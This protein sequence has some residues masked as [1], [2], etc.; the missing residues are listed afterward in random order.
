MTFPLKLAWLL[1]VAALTF[2]SLRV[3]AQDVYISEV[4]SSNDESLNDEDG[5]SPDWIELFNSSGSAV[6]LTGW[7][8]TDDSEDLTK[9]TFPATTIPAKGFLIVFASDKDRAVANQELHTNFKLS[10]SGEYIALVQADGTTIEN[11]HTLGAQV[12]DVSYGYVFSAGSTEVLLD[13]GAPCEVRVPT[14]ASDSSDWKEINATRSGWTSGTTGVGYEASSGY[15]HL[16][17]LDVIS[18][19]NVNASVY[20]AVPFTISD[21]ANVSNLTLKMKYEDGFAGYINGT[22]VATTGNVPANPL[23]NSEA[24]GNRNDSQ[25]IL[26]E[27]FDLSDAISE[28]QTG[29]NLLAIHAMNFLIG[30]S[31]LLVIPRLE[32]TFAGDIDTSTKGLLESPTPGRSNTGIGYAG[33]VDNAISASP[34]RGFYDSTISVTLSNPTPSTTLRYTT[35]GSEPTE[36]S[37]LYAGPISISST[38]TLRSKAFRT[39]WKPSL[40][41]TDTYIYASQVANRPKATSTVNGQALD[42]G[43]NSEV[44]AN[45]YYDSSDELVT[46]EDALLAIPSIS[47]TTDHDNLY[48]PTIGIYVNAQDR[49]EVPASAELI[50]PDGSEGFQINAGLR[51]RGG[52]SRSA[53]NPKHSFRLFFRGEYGFSKLNYPLFEDEGVDEFDKID[54][55]SAQNYSWSKDNDGRNT[56]LRDVF[57]RDISA[58]MNHAY[59]RSRYYHL[60]VNGEYW[61]LFM[62]EERPEAAFGASYFG[63]NDEDYDTIKCIGGGLPGAYTIE[64]ND[65]TIDAYER[66]Y[67]AAMA[68]FTNSDDYFAIQ[69]LDANGNPDPSNEKL[70]DVDNMVDYLLVLYYMAASDNAISWFIG[71]FSGLNNMYA[72]YNRA[73]PDG[74]K[75]IHHDSEHSLD[76]NRQEDVTGPFN[77]DN[78]EDLEYFNPMTLH[79][80]LSVNEEYKIKFA[81]R[82]YK[83][84]ENDGILTLAKSQARLDARAAQIDRAIVANSAK[85]GNVFLDRDTWVFAYTTTRDW[86]ARSGDRAVEVI[87]Y[88]DADGLIPSISPPQISHAD[89]LLESGTSIQLT[90]SS[91]T[92]YFTT[93]GSDPRAVGGSIA[94]EQYNSAPVITRPTHLKARARSNSGEWSALAE[95]TYWTEDVPLAITELMYHAPEG[96]SNDLI[97]LQNISTETITLKGYKLDDGIGFNFKNSAITTLA[98][99]EILVVVEDID[100]FNTKYPNSGDVLVAGEFSGNL[101]NGGEELDLEFRGEDVISFT[102]DD[103]RNWPQAADG[104][105]HSLVPQD[106]AIHNQERGTLNYG[107]NW[108][109]STYFGGSPGE[110]DPALSPTVVLNEIT[111]HTDT[112]NAAPFDSNDVIELYNP[113][114][115]TID[116]TGYYLSD[117]LEN[118]FQWPIPDGTTISGY[119]FI[120]FDEDDFHS[121]RVNGFGLNKAGEEVVL[122]T[123][124]RVVDTIRFK[125]QENGVSYGRYPDGSDHWTLTTLSRDTDNT[126]PSAGLQISEIMYHPATPG[127]DQEFVVIENTGSS[128]ISLSNSTGN[129][130][131]DG[132]I[133]FDFP[134]GTQLRSG[135]RLWLVSFDPDVDTDKL[136]SFSFVNGVSR[137]FKIIGPYSNSLPN[138]VGRVALERPQDSDDPLNPLDV[139]W[140]V[141]DEVYYAD[142]SP[143]PSTADGTGFPLIRTSLNTWSALT[144]DD[145]DAD[146]ID[147]SWETFYFQSLDQ[148]NLD[149]DND[150]YSNYQE[151]IANSD[152]TNGNSFFKLTSTTKANLS[153]EVL[154]G[155]VY[156]VYKAERLDL[157]FQLIATG[158][159]AG[160]YIDTAAS[161]D[162]QCFYYITVELE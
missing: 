34:A 18:M 147:D 118:L 78:F 116:L 85:W 52:A 26:F 81:D 15:E 60:Y 25:A 106:S 158:I 136:S 140:V 86:L 27:E 39:D 51:I 89:G 73:D 105:G 76:T 67:N 36:S 126:L 107:G 50:Y 44:L 68:G 150:G 72:I 11:A 91:G 65:G 62:T 151:F 145:T 1:I 109:A 121:D 155:R 3:S 29:N 64:A 54:L 100:A 5:D 142:Q 6:T 99:S 22:K 71:R 132:D 137:R 139:S 56:F 66:L 124:N 49:V 102:Y 43:M 115:N 55:R 63:G 40:S 98:P 94:G 2:T 129:Y 127:S 110:V 160:S 108:R 156:S 152:P 57:A 4:V 53:S 24:S 141:V 146:G 111:A 30:S 161:E 41:R 101:D 33:F 79:E 77:S 104:T 90:A 9:W 7:H 70:L 153:W 23:W 83:H 148:T 113:T 88:L 8:L 103:A 59:T 120:T 125:G 138:N 87:G 69:G 17:N 47:L 20:I 42:F 14:S 143:W 12:E 45:E 82:V 37:P 74:F 38:T 112:G 35:D 130:R 58:E 97:E 48:D 119:G 10:A 96:N 135:E 93:D 46:V 122:S 95:S 16:I 114:P 128:T 32:A 131:I 28:L 21:A 31:D 134:S 149:F 61:G 159:R 154:P 92:I 162:D 117:D 123:A 133:D 144:D 75:W 19:Q 13:A 80:K 84:L 157:P